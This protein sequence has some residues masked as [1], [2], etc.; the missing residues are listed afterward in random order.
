M[1]AIKSRVIQLGWLSNN[2]RHHERYWILAEKI[3]FLDRD[4]VVNRLVERNG[5]MVSPRTANDFSLLPDVQEAI[6]K[7]GRF[8][9]EVVVVTNQPDISRGLMDISELEKMNKLV[10]EVGVTV[11]RICPHSNDDNCLCRKPKPGLLAQHIE[12]CDSEPEVIWM[13]GDN[14]S[15]IFAGIAVQ[16]RTIL[17][18]KKIQ[19]SR[20]S[21]EFVANDLLE[22]VNL[23]IKNS[24]D[25]L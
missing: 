12:R 11:I 15:D 8:G 17:I 21:S 7:L 9:F 18:S 5:E 13:I 6:E 4:G 22:A 14:E 3:V 19:K 16:A 23:I 10:Y 24:E 1:L 20:S 2:Y 25:A